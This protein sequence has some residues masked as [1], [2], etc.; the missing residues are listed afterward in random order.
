VS[1]PGEGSELDVVADE[2]YG[3]LA[4]EFTSARD[5]RAASARQAGDRQLAGEIKK[6]R[7]PT[8]SAWLTNQL[9]RDRQDEISALLELGS[10]LRDAQ[11]HLAGDDL[12]R[13]SQQGQQVVTALG[14]E[15]R[16][17]AVDRGVRVADDT[18]R[19]VEET[20]HAALADPA[21]SAAVSAG[22]L[23]AALHYAGFGSL[24]GVQPLPAKA[25]HRERSGRDVEEESARQEA[26]AELSAA[27]REVGEQERH[28]ERARQQQER[29]D[30][31]VRNLSDELEQLRADARE[32]RD[33][34]RDAERALGAA[35]QRLVR[36]Q[37][38]VD[39]RR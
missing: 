6:L 23:P 20:L 16:Q 32:A 7:R 29:L 33:A 36:A 19:E 31:R 30:H 15:A 2:L 35:E 10:A 3:L 12:R 9:V 1:R 11:A 39:G 4:S 26:Q 8:A 17:L 5:R 28:L 25:P 21:A 13:L 37:A 14:R 22:H 27:G 34:V 24:D 18:L 38:V